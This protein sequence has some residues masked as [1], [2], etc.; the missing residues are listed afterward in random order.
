MADMELVRVIA[1]DEEATEPEAGQYLLVDS[2]DGTKKMQVETL[3]QAA[4][5]SD[6]VKSALLTCFQK[7]AWVDEHGQD[8]YDALEDALSGDEFPKITVE[9]NLRGHKVFTSDAIDTL[10]NYL[11][12]KYYETSESSGTTLSSNQYSLSGT[13]SEGANIILVTYSEL[14]AMVIV[15][16]LAITIPSA[17]TRYDYI[18]ARDDFSAADT[19]YPVAG[20]IKAILGKNLNALSYYSQLYVES[21]FSKTGGVA[22]FGGRT[23]S[24]STSSVAIYYNRTKEWLGCH[25]HGTDPNVTPPGQINMNE[26][27]DV[28]LYNGSA[29]PSLLSAGNDSYEVPW[30]N[31]D[32]V[33][34]DL[35]LLNNAKSSDTTAYMARY[36]R[37][38]NVDILNLNAERVHYLVPAIRNSDNVI[39]WY[40]GITGTFFTTSNAIY[41]TVGNS[42]C[43]YSV[44]DW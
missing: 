14:T 9:I 20:S 27:T 23:E 35:T 12:V 10:K 1:L 31:N 11:T 13:L 42:S 28:S 24:G 40:D 39:G 33:S 37:V 25:V 26:V 30:T 2:P 44:G 4:G 21:S 41:A 15:S 22:L 43:A 32:N 7:V 38:G 17:Y 18:K 19:G 34:A 8:Y 16:A 3:L 29:S 5:L 36:M 6:A